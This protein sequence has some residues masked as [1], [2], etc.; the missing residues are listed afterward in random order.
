MRLRKRESGIFEADLTPMIDM[1]FQLIAFFMVII[2]FAQTEQNAKVQL[3]DSSLVKA[4]DKPFENQL[5]IHLARDG[6]AII[7]GQEMPI[8]GLGIIL[9]RE[10]R[11][12][13][14][15]QSRVSDATVVVRAHK[16]ARAGDVQRLIKK[17]QEYG[18]EKFALRAKG[19]Q[20]PKYISSG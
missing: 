2:N 4:P 9:G 18:F 17:C 5:I 8:D 19:S 6:R 12:L 15:T 16:Y 14:I 7:N 10:A 13:E 20:K 11:A 3:P 1:T